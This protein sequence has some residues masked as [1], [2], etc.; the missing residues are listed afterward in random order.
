ML[1]T[2]LGLSAPLYHHHRLMLAADGR[3][4]SKSNGAESLATLRRAGHSAEEVRRRAL[5]A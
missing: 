2:L 5:A 3:K 4:L 1:Q